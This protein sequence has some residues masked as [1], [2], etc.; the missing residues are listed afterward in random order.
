MWDLGVGMGVDVMRGLRC[1]WNW[2]EANRKTKGS[3]GMWCLDARSVERLWTDVKSRVKSPAA[4]NASDG[5]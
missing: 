4:Y 5:Q 3:K 1:V 2:K